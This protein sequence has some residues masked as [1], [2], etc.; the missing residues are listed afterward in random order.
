M[1]SI[2]LSTRPFHSPHPFAPSARPNPLAQV[3]SIGNPRIELLTMH[4]ASANGLHERDCEVARQRMVIMHAAAPAPSGAPPPPQQPQPPRQ[5]PAPFTIV[6]PSRDAIAGSALGF[7]ASGHLCLSHGDAS[8]PTFPR[9]ALAQYSVSPTL[10]AARRGVTPHS[11]IMLPL[12]CGGR[13]SGGG[14]SVRASALP[15][16]AAAAGVGAST[17]AGVVDLTD[18]DNT[19]PSTSTRDDSGLGGDGF[20]CRT[21]GRSGAAVLVRPWCLVGSH[22]LSSVA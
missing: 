21:V 22:N 16:A 15:S 7:H 3:S 18:V 14:G 12:G 19:P 17:A 11:K 2:A 4:Y 5:G 20:V 8:K 9:F 6:F 10:L 13:D 1:H